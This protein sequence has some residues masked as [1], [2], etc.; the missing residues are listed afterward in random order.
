MHIGLESE[1]E[2]CMFCREW[3]HEEPHSLN[4]AELDRN[5][6]EFS[7]E[8]GSGPY[9]TVIY[10]INIPVDVSALGTW[11]KT[12]RWPYH[13][14]YRP[15]CSER[16]KARGEGDDRGWDGWMALLT[17][18]TW[19]WINSESWWWTGRPGML[20]SMGSQRVRHDWATELNWT[21]P[22]SSKVKKNIIILLSSL[23][24]FFFQ[25]AYIK[26]W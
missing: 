15:R 23:S 3:R 22:F 26:I 10:S 6:R 18:W 16:L 2:A 7:Y 13:W 4:Q 5:N 14:I 20:Q 12:V 9:A 1:R 25:W 8:W 19:V 17:Q 11:R 24:L 21:K